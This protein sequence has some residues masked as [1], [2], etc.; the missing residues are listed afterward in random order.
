MIGHGGGLP[1]TPELTPAELVA[2]ATDQLGV[3]LL[4]WQARLLEALLHGDRVVYHRGRRG[5]WT[6]VQAVARQLNVD[7]AL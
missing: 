3:E 7:D 5:G 1:P 4:P 6:T 2:R